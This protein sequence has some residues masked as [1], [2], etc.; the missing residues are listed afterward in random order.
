[1]NVAYETGQSCSQPNAQQNNKLQCWTWHDR[2]ILCSSSPANI[3]W[4]ASESHAKDPSIHEH[5]CVRVLDVMQYSNTARLNTICFPV[6]ML[7]PRPCDHG[8]AHFHAPSKEQT[9]NCYFFSVSTAD[10]SASHSWAWSRS[11]YA[12]QTCTGWKVSMGPRQKGHKGLANPLA[13]IWY[14]HCRHICSRYSSCTAS[15]ECECCEKTPAVFHKH[16]Q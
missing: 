4:S 13:H 11:W 16:L 14:A 15:W 12:L 2:P 8:V 1:M 5:K 10:S 7:L 9:S 3:R 6:G